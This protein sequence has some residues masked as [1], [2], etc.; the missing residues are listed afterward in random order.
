M[1]GVRFGT[2]ATGLTACA[3]CAY[4][5]SHARTTIIPGPGED[6]SVT[7]KA[8]SE[9][10]YGPNAPLYEKPFVPKWTKAEAIEEGTKA[11]GTFG[12]RIRIKMAT[13]VEARYDQRSLNGKYQPGFWMLHWS[14]VDDRGNP[15]LDD[16]VTMEIPEG[17][18]SLW[19][20][21]EQ[22]SVYAEDIGEPFS[23]EEALTKIRSKIES[24]EF[25]DKIE[26]WHQ[27]VGRT[28]TSKGSE[29]LVI[30]HPNH[31]KTAPA[32]LAWDFWFNYH[33]SD[34]IEMPPHPPVHYHFPVEYWLDAHTGAIIGEDEG[35]TDEPD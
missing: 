25:W 2:L 7:D 8:L 34:T 10:L 30:V 15:F 20:E 21:V 27:I 26:P 17:Y 31:D 11:L 29:S 9:K 33:P 23:R 35:G 16:G 6:F 28:D 19:I 22:S 32:R 18:H 1:K 12:P 24:G 5:L 14:R 4:L 3:V 13:E